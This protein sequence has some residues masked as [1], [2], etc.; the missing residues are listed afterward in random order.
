MICGQKVDHKHMSITKTLSSISRGQ[1][2]LIKDSKILNKPVTVLK[3]IAD[4][5]L[6]SCFNF[7]LSFIIMD[8]LFMSKH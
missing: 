8:K 6:I 1:S 2:R 5:A 4:C 7:K 3:T